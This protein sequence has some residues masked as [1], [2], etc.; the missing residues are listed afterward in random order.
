MRQARVGLLMLLFLGCAKVNVT[1]LGSTADGRKQFAITC[2]MSA[3]NDGTCHQQAAAACGG[4][5]ETLSVSSTGP[6]PLSPSGQTY[7]PG[8]RVL[9]VACN[10]HPAS[11]EARA[12]DRT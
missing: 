11:D 4:S 12:A 7:V 9:L 5:Y 1:P 3:S 8:D 6:R 10:G 2:N